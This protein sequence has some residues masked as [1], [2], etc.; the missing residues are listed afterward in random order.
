MSDT[1]V[2]SGYCALFNPH[3]D[4]VVEELVETVSALRG[5]PPFEIS[6]LYPTVDP[7]ALE[8]LFGE[9]N[10]SNWTGSRVVTFDYEGFEVTI[11]SN[12][13]M[14]LVPVDTA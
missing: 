12:G 2:P 9:P 10:A 4:S 13:C 7:D 11:R 1:S 14:R 6:P 5:A 3:V 8:T